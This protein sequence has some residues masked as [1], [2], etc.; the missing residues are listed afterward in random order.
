MEHGGPGGAAY[1]AWLLL[2]PLCPGS[3][4]G[5]ASANGP[6]KGLGGDSTKGKHRGSVEKHRGS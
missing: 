4:P 1:K 6:R 5:V 2:P 3:R